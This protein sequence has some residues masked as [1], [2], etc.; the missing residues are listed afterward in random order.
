MGEWERLDTAYGT[1]MRPRRRKFRRF[2][3]LFL[4][5]LMILMIAGAGAAWY[6][7]TQMP[8]TE[9]I[10]PD[11]MAET[12][13]I[14]RGGE[15]T[16][17]FALGEGEG[18]LIP[19]EL[20]SQLAPDSVRYE[21][22][23][24][25]VI[26]TTP[27]KVLQFQVGKA[28]ASLNGKAISMQFAATHHGS[29]VY[30]PFAPFKELLGFQ[31]EVAPDTGIVT[32]FAPDEAVQQGEISPLAEKGAALRTGPGK[33]FP[34][35]EDMM[36]GSRLYIRGEED[37]W[38]RVQSE[39]GHVGYADKR[40]VRLTAI[41]KIPKPAEEPPFVAWKLTGQ[42]INMTW[43]AVYE[44]KPD[45]RVIGELPGV[46]VVSP[47]WFELMDGD[48]NIR[49]KA[50]AAYTEW[51][52][53]R[54]VQVWALFSNGFDPER[55]EQ[56]LATYEK[57]KK[58]IDQLLAYAQ[59]FKLQGINI[60]FENVKTSDKDNLVQFVRELT[61]L[62][63]EQNL[64]I[65]IDVTP[66]SNSEFWSLF[67]DR[68]RLGQ[69]VDYMMVMAY[70]EHWATSPKAG[71]VSSLPWA[72]NAIRRILE[73]DGVPSR[74]LVL[75]IPLYT[76][77]W[78]EEP[79]GQGGVKVSS[80]ALGMSAVANIIAEKKLQPVVAP[81]TGQHYV[82]YK[83]GNAVKKIWI[84]DELSIEAR[85]QIVRKYNLAG[86]ASW[87]RSFASGGIWEVMDRHLQSRP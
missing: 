54:G 22:G 83:E 34:I 35:I 28:E 2:F 20:A 4:F 81:E 77:V 72:E 52:R 84:E 13:P 16:G 78:T 32:I 19:L 75:G 10:V 56:A 15:W 57:R 17:S 73:E 68:R 85:M 29:Q 1:V 24:D 7:A 58:M 31:A 8:S 44:R 23:S 82:S 76:R 3:A 60:D 69:I 74:K 25:T 63:H 59:T 5:F 14:M 18:L 45:P 33:F 37:G 40:L 71:S 50:D 64:V 67:L 46:N 48:G 86:I 70:D 11:Y 65:S 55:T 47:T 61:P 41:E 79:D 53:A 6:V 42:R 38:Y 12:G 51:Y 26:M 9:R 49:S 66:K 36:P 43:E 39:T 21:E 27:S 87:A 30:L 62:A 80:R